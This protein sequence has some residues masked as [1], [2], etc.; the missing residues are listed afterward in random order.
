MKL[1]FFD[2]RTLKREV[3]CVKFSGMEQITNSEKF[4]EQYYKLKSYNV[5]QMNPTMHFC[6]LGKLCVK[7]YLDDNFIFNEK[8]SNGHWGNF[9]CFNG[10]PDFLIY[11]LKDEEV[12]ELFFV[13]V[14]SLNDGVRL[15]QLNWFNRTNVPGKIVFVDFEVEK[16]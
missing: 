2:I 3:I 8:N 10:A 7:H 6:H 15:N 13:E 16:K 9:C 4:I 1:Y 14:K 5:V 12:V 11:K